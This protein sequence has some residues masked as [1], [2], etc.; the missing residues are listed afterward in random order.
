MDTDGDGVPDLNEEQDGT[1]PENPDTDGDG[2]PDGEELNHGLDPLNSSSAFEP[3]DLIVV[4]FNE[5]DSANASITPFYRWYTFDQYLNGS[6]GL[7]QSAY[8]LTLLPFSQEIQGGIADQ[9]VWGGS[10]HVWDVS[11]VYPGLGQP[12]SQA[13]LPYNILSITSTV[14]PDVTLNVTNSTRD[15]IIDN[16]FLDSLKVNALSLIHI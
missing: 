10:S 1:D 13:I 12:G 9:S 5:A 8:G 7:N 3:N 4:G 6:W 11:Y 2:I 16:S 14:E 15:L